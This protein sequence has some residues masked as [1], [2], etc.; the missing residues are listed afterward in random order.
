[1]ECIE[2][3]GARLALAFHPLRLRLSRV[4]I[5]VILAALRSG[6]KR[7]E[8]GL[9]RYIR[10]W[11]RRDRSPSSALVRILAFLCDGWGWGFSFRV[12]LSRERSDIG[13][14]YIPDTCLGPAPFAFSRPSRAISLDATRRDF[15]RCGFST[16]FILPSR[17]RCIS[18]Q[19]MSFNARFNQDGRW[20][21]SCQCISWTS[22]RFH[23]V[24]LIETH[25][26]IFLIRYIPWDAVTMLRDWKLW[27]HS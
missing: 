26:W 1:M 20:P 4:S 23:V 11:H 22:R 10:R 27:P 18:V 7:A 6:A 13:I 24:T 2:S 21:L 25:D 9:P 12:L 8:K 15:S 3:S 19:L 17:R 5:V 16:L 14:T